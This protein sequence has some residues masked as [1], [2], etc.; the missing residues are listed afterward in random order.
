MKLVIFGTFALGAVMF[1]AATG[2]AQN[3]LGAF[4]IGASSGMIIGQVTRGDN[5]NG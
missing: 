3:I 4:L 5:G 2:P 1:A